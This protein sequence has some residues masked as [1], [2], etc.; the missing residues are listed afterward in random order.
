MNKTLWSFIFIFG[1]ISSAPLQAGESGTWR[2]K[3][4][5]GTVKYADKPPEGIE[6]EFIK[7]SAPKHGKAGSEAKV[8]NTKDEIAE[9]KGPQKMEGLP[10][11]DPALCKQAQ[12]NL[13][14]L[15]AARIRI[16]EPDGS[17]RLLN[18]E[19][20]EEQRENARKFIKVHC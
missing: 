19:E 4:E 9:S 13:K 17:K 2:W 16:T 7:F 14:A 6:A 12:R 1:L 20:K 10:A 18:E 15:E 8:E 3:D 11:K 5:N